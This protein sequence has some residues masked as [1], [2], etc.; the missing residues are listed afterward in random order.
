VLTPTRRLVAALLLT[1]A[2]TPL[3]LG[4][5]AAFGIYPAGTSGMDI[6]YP[7]CNDDLPASPTS[8]AI[9]GVSG[10]RAFYQNPCL[11]KEFAWAQTASV[12]PSFFINL[13][14]PGGSVAFKGNTGPRGNCAQTDTLC[15]AYNFGYNDAR[16][17]YADAQSQETAA[18][19]WWLDVEEEN[20]WS[21]DKN[22]NAQVVQGAI[23]FLRSQNRTI[24]VYSTGK[25]WGELLGAYSPGLPNWIGGAPDSDTAP[26]YCDP[27]QAFGGGTVWLVQYP[28]GNYDADYACGAAP[29]SPSTPTAFQATAVSP[30]TIQLSWTAPPGGADSYAIWNGVAVIASVQ[31]SA[32]TY[33]VTGLAPRSYHCFSIAT[34]KG[35][36]YSAWSSYACITTPGS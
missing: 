14:A 28:S 30:T 11:I 3:K 17:A 8:F 19:M 9:I 22:A 34:Q 26:S 18:T 36:S 13:N 15:I 29:V 32:T 12:A 5:A 2:L 27:S 10:G 21:D 20:T 35:N 1:L 4:H 25:Q 7:A 24:G 6:S 16:L 33:T 23:D 31:P